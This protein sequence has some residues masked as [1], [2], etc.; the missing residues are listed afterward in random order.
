MRLA[1]WLPHEP[2]FN[3]LFEFVRAAQETSSA[4]EQLGEYL[5]SERIDRRTDDDRTLVIG[6]WSGDDH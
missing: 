1:D 3:P 6:V 5:R 4:T 2:F